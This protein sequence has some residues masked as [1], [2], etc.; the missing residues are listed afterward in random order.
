MSFTRFSSHSRHAEC[1]VVLLLLIGAAGCSGSSGGTQE[2]GGTAAIGGFTA[3]GGAPSVG[4]IHSTGGTIAGGATRPAMR[5]P[6]IQRL[7]SRRTLAPVTSM[8]RTCLRWATPL[9]GE[10]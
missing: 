7:V 8:I 6:I 3:V 10:V 4:G 1:H 5:T 2:V 9:R